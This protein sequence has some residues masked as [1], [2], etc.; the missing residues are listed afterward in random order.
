MGHALAFSPDGQLLAT[1]PFPP[2]EDKNKLG[3]F[4]LWDPATAKQLCSVEV[5][6]AITPMGRQHRRVHH[7]LFS[8]DGRILATASR[9]D[10]WQ[11]ST[12][13]SA[14]HLWPLVRDGAGKSAVRVGPPRLLAEGFHAMAGK[15]NSYW[16]RAWAFSPD[17]RTLALADEDSTVRLVETASGG[18]ERARFT[19]HSDAVT[20]LSF[21]PSGRRLA[22]GSD[23]TTIL[24]WDL[25]GRLQ[26]ER[27]RPVQLSDKELERL[28]TDLAADDAGRAGRAIWTLA[29]AGNLGVPYLAERL[30]TV[31]ADVKARLAKVPQLLRDLDEDAFAVR[32]K[33]RVELARLGVVAEPALRQALAKSPSVEMRRSLEDLLKAVEGKHYGLYGGELLRGVRAVEVLEQI[34]T[35][36]ACAALKALAAGAGTESALTNEARAALERLQRAERR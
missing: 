27:L 17:G 22:S 14:I 8:P 23:D 25:T 7:L 16:L 36:E 18:K 28:W 33:A 30:R 24:V 2:S 3:S 13:G 21:S 15:A 29:A 35:P 12:R 6:D 5:P 31:T 11:D 9:E 26:G 20:A 4:L 19:G 32:K 1:A 10:R 34:G